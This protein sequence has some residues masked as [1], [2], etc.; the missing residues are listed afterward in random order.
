M[1]DSSVTVTVYECR[2]RKVRTLRVAESY[3][4]GTFDAASVVW[5]LTHDSPSERLI[6]VYLNS[7]SQILGV[8][9]CAVGSIVGVE[10]SPANVLRAALLLNAT[11]VIVGHNHPSNS[12]V[13]SAE[14]IQ[15]TRQLKAACDAVGLQLLDHLIVGTDRGKWFSFCESAP[16]G[17]GFDSNP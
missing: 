5:S 4:G 8:E 6:G 16:T 2:L 10:L 12:L 7:S 1:T 13:P 3:V 11:R 9:V 15:M 17:S 14:D